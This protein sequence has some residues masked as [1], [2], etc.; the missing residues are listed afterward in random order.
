MFNMSA[1]QHGFPNRNF[2]RKEQVL[3]FVYQW[4]MQRDVA[5]TCIS[6][7]YSTGC[8]SAPSLGTGVQ[9]LLLAVSQ[10]TQY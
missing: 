5:P 9:P 4:K 2:V 7:F 6:L 10:Q 8:D 3:A 1:A